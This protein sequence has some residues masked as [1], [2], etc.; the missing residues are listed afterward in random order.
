MFVVT[1]VI[2]LPITLKTGDP[3]K[4]W[5]AGLVWVFFQSFI[6]MIG[7]FIA[8]YIR[9]ITPRAALLGTL[10]GVSVTFISM[11]PALEMYMTP[12][13]G[14]PCFA[15]ILVAWFGGVRYPKGIPAGLVAI[16]AGMLIAWGSTLVG[17]NY[18][19]MTL[20]KV[21]QAVA[22]FGFSYPKPAH[23]R[24]VRRVRVP[25][26]HPGHRHPVR[27]L[28]PGRGDG[29]RRE[30]G[31]RRRRVPDHP[32]ADRRRRGQP[33]RLPD[34]QSLHQRGLHRPSRLEGDGRPHRLLRR[35]RPDGDRA[36]VVRHH[37]AAALPGAR[38]RHLADPALH[39]HADRRAGVPGDAQGACARRGAVAG[40][41]SRRLV[42]DA[43]GRRAARRPA[44]TRTPSASTSW[45]RSACST[46]GSRCW[47]AAPFSPG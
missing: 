6:L 28:R 11:R 14:I 47:A 27:H 21:G 33:D 34:G 38:G 22:S 2:M 41:A 29:Q 5:Q 4:G 8:P 10:A 9:R 45:A 25:R 39:R 40:A 3:I 37:R 13:I 31:S 23:Q 24:G 19:G 32:G 15:I 20:Q 46:T 26:H 1:F 44:P 7:G 17:L 18:G 12:I 30:R 36:V 16:A 43:D 35:D 42:Q